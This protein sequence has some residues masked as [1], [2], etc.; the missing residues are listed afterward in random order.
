[1]SAEDNLLFSVFKLCERTKNISV[2]ALLSRWSATPGVE[3]N[4]PLASVLSFDSVRMFKT[5]LQFP[6]HMELEETL[7]FGGDQHLY[8]PYFVVLL[9]AQM[10]AN[11][12]HY[13]AADWVHIFRTNVVCLIMRSMS[14]R[15]RS[16]RDMATALLAKLWQRLQVCLA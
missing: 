7:S 8:N 16:L 6:Q 5:C 11:T 14:A 3:S 9:F 2:A 12:S 10:L 13:S 4:E 15:S 1:M